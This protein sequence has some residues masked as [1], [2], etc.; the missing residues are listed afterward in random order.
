MG[1]LLVGLGGTLGTALRLGLSLIA[2]RYAAE[3]VYLS[4]LAANVL[5]A[6]LIGYLATRDLG[7]SARALW[8]T[9]FCGGFTTFSFFSLEVVMLLERGAGLALGYAAASLV[10]WLAALWL[11]VV[12]GRGS[13]P[14]G[15]PPTR[16]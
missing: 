8:M 15:S 4:T 11:G 12:L 7:A 5:G 3:Y 1:F 2:L 10:L 13:A 9:G 16:P 6:A 14:S